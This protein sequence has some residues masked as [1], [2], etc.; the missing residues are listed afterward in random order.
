MRIGY[1]KLT[2]FTDL[3]QIDLIKN[4]L[5]ELEKP[6][7]RIVKQDGT[8]VE[9]IYNIWRIGSRIEG[10]SRLDG[11]IFEINLNSKSVVFSFYI[12]AVFEVLWT[13][14]F[15]FIAFTEDRSILFFI[16]FIWLMF[17]I[18]MVIVKNVGNRMIE[19][20]VNC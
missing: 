8:K 13:L 19:N 5:G 14:F 3:S 20:I 15:A 2:R 16:V 18:R 6:G 10:F 1:K 11:G 12:S 9:F 17:I 4:I 7:Y